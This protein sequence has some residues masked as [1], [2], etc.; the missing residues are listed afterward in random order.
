M[1]KVEIPNKVHKEV[2]KFALDHDISIK[3]AYSSLVEYALE[4]KHDR[5]AVKK[6]LKDKTSQDDII[7]GS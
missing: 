4:Q 2:K 6:I 5:I 7:V 3:D 1:S